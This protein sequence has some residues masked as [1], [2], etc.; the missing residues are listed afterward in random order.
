MQSSFVGACLDRA[1]RLLRAPA[2]PRLAF[3]EFG[4]VLTSSVRL[5][6]ITGIEKV[7]SGGTGQERWQLTR[8]FLALRA[9]GLPKRPAGWKLLK[10]QNLLHAPVAVRGYYKN[11]SGKV[12]RCT[13]PKHCIVM[14]LALLPVV[15]Q[16]ETRV[17][18][19]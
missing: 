10:A 16:L 2:A 19:T 7:M 9:A 17:A 8:K 5:Q 15:D 6:Q 1:V 12:P 11:L 14:K 13:N 3:T 18:I 4:A